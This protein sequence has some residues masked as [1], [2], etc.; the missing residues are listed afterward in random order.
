MK[1]VETFQER[2]E[3]ALQIRKMKPV[4]LHEKTGI[5]E[6]LISKYLSGRA[7][8]RQKKIS[9]LA[10]ALDVSPVWLLGYDVPIEKDVKLD[11]LGNPVTLIPILRYSKSWI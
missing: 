4:A 3:K 11:S 9:L 7:V 6:S 1:T 8:A 5:S 2:L 10:D